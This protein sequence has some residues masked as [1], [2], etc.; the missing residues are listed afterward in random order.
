MVE[1]EPAT[2]TVSLPSDPPDLQLA[3]G[4]SGSGLGTAGDYAMVDWRVVE[5]GCLGE[6]VGVGELRVFQMAA[7]IVCHTRSDVTGMSIWRTPR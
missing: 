6:G 5:S 4:V 3:G 1:L 7:F 2:S